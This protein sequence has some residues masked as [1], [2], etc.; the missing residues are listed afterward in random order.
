M[1]LKLTEEQRKQVLSA[2][3]NKELIELDIFEPEPKPK[4][5]TIKLD[6]MVG[7]DIDC[8]FSNMATPFKDRHDIYIGQ[9]TGFDTSIKNKKFYIKDNVS[10]HYKC[11]I[12]QDHR[13]HWNGGDC[14]LPEGLDVEIEF[15]ESGREPTDNY[16]NL[17]WSHTG[18]VWDII[19]FKVLGTAENFK[20]EWQIKKRLIE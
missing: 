9:L 12:R 5:K 1:K 10:K 17:R 7:S 15:R 6:E 14:P 18:G 4:Q 20:Y 2:Y 3:E 13:H 16:R 19:A 11:R 8:E